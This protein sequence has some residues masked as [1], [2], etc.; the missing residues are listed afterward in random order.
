M[1]EKAETLLILLLYPAELIEAFASMLDLNQRPADPK[2]YVYP[3]PRTHQ[4][5]L[6]KEQN[7][8]RES[9]NPVFKRSNQLSYIR[10]RMTGFEPATS[11][12]E[13]SN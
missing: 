2:K 4:N 12:F 6:P 11:S 7:A 13:G 3:T 5:G 10:Y 9:L 8:R 1:R